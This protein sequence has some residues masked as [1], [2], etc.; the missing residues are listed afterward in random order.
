M[1]KIFVCLLVILLPVLCKAQRTPHQ[2]NGPNYTATY[3]ECIQYYKNLAKVYKGIQVKQMGTTDAG[4]PLHVILIN[5][6]NNFNPT[7]WHATN[8]CVLLINNGIHPGE[9]DGIDAS[10]QLCTDVLQQIKQNKFSSNICLAI[11]PVYNIGGALNRSTYYRVD[12]NGPNAFGSRG[13][14]ANLDLNRDFIKADSKEASSFAEIFH[15]VQPH[16]FLDNH[17][18]DGADY[19][20]TMTLATTQKDKLGGVL[21][22]YLTQQLEPAIFKAMQQQGMEMIPYVNA[23]GRDAKLGWPQFFDSPRYSSGY[24][25]LFNTLAF[26]PESHMLKP[27]TKRVQA[28]YTLMQCFIN[29]ATQ[30]HTALVAL[31]KQA[32]QNMLAQNTFAIAWANDKDS[33]TKLSYKGYTYKPIISKVSGLPVYVYDTA[34]PYTASVPFYN[35]YKTTNSVNAPQAYIIPQGWHKVIQL[36]Q[37]NK[38]LMYRFGADTTLPVNMYHIDAYKSSSTPYEGH[39][40]NSQVQVSSAYKIMQYRKGDYYVPTQQLAK[41]FI[42]ETLEPHAMDSYFTWNFFDAILIQKEGFTDYAFEAI[43]AN[44]LQTNP[45]LQDSLNAKRLADTSFANSAEAQLEYV[46]KHSPYYEPQHLWYPVARVQKQ[47]SILQQNKNAD[48]LNKK[49]E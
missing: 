21:S 14:S 24:A 11:I 1:Y 29:Y 41:R 23:W 12:Q 25:T 20:Y 35:Y 33:S 27:Y 30:H 45:N 9:P 22:T 26:V 37:N 44:Y 49:D 32:I 5:A 40:A 38:V 39:H 18:S 17:V 8:K 3:T 28:T 46:Y 47:A 34:A 6:Q 19:T 43:A 10:M 7:Q 36:L 16:I 31:K 4:L 42:I 48:M 13:N 15:Y 2:V